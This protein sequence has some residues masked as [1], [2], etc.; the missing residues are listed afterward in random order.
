M[1]DAQNLD[2]GKVCR[3]VAPDAFG[4]MSALSQVSGDPS[5]T[6]GVNQKPQC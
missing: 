5:I 2:V 6:T 4:V 1:R 3:I